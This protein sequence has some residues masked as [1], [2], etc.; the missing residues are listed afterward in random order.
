[1]GRRPVFRSVRDL[2][3][4]YVDPFVDRTGRVR[5]Y[6]AFDLRDLRGVDWGL[7]RRN[8]WRV[9]EALLR[10]PHR[11]LRASDARHARWHARYLAWKAERPGEEPPRR[12]YPGADRMW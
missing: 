7:S 9:E 2:A 4:S 11:P 12:F 5:G 3:W 10:N 8:V 6:A 1:M